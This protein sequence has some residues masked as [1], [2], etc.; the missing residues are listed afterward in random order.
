MPEIEFRERTARLRAMMAQKGINV[1][2]LYGS[3]MS[4]YGHQSY[5]SNYVPES[6]EGMVVIVPECGDTTLVFEGV[7]RGLASVQNT[8]WISDIRASENL[9]KACSDY[10]TGNYPNGITIGIV[11]FKQLMPFN[12]WR[13]FTEYTK[14]YHVTDWTSTLQEMRMVKSSRE[15]DQIRRASR[16]VGRA[17]DNLSN[18]IYPE[19]NERSIEAEI[20]RYCYLEG[21]EDVRVLLT[22]PLCK[23]R[24]FRPA[25]NGR[26]ID[27]KSISVYLAMAYEAYWAEGIRTYGFQDFNVISPE[28]IDGYRMILRNLKKGMVI[29]TFYNK[30]SSDLTLGKKCSFYDYPG[31][32]IGLALQEYPFISK[33]QKT[34]L[35]KG[36]CLTLRLISDNEIGPTITGHTLLVTENAPEILT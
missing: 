18:I 35:K 2:L 25:E 16:I 17:F 24:I 28:T 29:S 19:I 20:E 11:G 13:S 26:K 32:S 4:E 30:T 6:A 33:N 10:L 14:M 7:A 8:T 9:A 1:I 5:I 15:S 3:G 12:Q 23:D 31:N 22:Y 21:A 34:R 27:S 36:M